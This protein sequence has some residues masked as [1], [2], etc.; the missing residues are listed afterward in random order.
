MLPVGK[1]NQGFTLIELIV[2]LVLIGISLAIVAPNIAKGLQDREVRG[3]ALSLAAVAR[4][5]RSQ[6]LFNG[7]PQQLVVN[8]PQGSYL[9]ARTRE[10]HLPED[11][12]F[13]SVEG[14]ESVDRDVRRFYFFPNGSSMGGE[15][16]LADSDKAISYSIRF[17]PLTGKIEVSRGDIS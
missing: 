7:I 5:L 11:V 10:V 3:A 6:A 8:L 9:V 1:N 13:L 15:I 2:V 16:V 12:K 14:G 4:D 17:E